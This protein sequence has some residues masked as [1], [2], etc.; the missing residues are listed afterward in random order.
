MLV[1]AIEALRPLCSELL[2]SSGVPM[3]RTL[4]FLLLAGGYN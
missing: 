3:N 2:N 1:W 4:V